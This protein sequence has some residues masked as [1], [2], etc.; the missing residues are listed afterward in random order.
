[1]YTV[2]LYFVST[3]VLQILI[4]KYF[5]EYGMLGFW[6]LILPTN[7]NI[8]DIYRVTKFL[9]EDSAYQYVIVIDM[10]AI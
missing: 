9:S 7:L 3:V 8:L 2:T 4:V 6:L 10:G 1:M 5:V